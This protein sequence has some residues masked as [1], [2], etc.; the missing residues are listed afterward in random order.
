MA[1]VAG[2]GVVRLSRSPHREGSGRH[3]V[4]VRPSPTLAFSTSSIPRRFHSNWEQSCSWKV[5]GQKQNRKRTS[6]R[7]AHLSRTFVIPKLGLLFR[8]AIQ[9]RRYLG[10]ALLRRCNAV[11]MLLW[12]ACSLSS[13][14]LSP[15]LRHREASCSL[16]ALFLC[17]SL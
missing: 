17:F 4:T 11:C 9:Q 15:M 16:V 13:S 14:Q 5:S 1:C 7:V 8:K 3:F 2:A 10:F 6:C 12:Y